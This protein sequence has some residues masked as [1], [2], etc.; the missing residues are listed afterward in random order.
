MLCLLIKEGKCLVETFVGYIK[1]IYSKARRMSGQCISYN[2]GSLLYELGK[3]NGA[4]LFLN[5]NCLISLAFG[6]K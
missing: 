1:V 2:N 4:H 6:S 5:E 3:Q